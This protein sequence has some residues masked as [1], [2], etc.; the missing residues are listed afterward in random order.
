MKKI[1]FTLLLFIFVLKVMGQQC[2]PINYTGPKPALA[3]NYLVNK[4]N[5]RFANANIASRSADI[6]EAWL[7]YAVNLEALI[8]NG[9]PYIAPLF[10]DSSVYFNYGPTSY[11][12]AFSYSIGQ[13]FNA[14]SVFFTSTALG[15]YGI[16][17]IDLT[18]SEAYTLDSIAP[19]IAYYRLNR[20]TSIVD[21]LVINLYQG[22]SQSTIFPQ[23]YFTGN[24]ASG[25]IDSYYGTDTVFFPAIFYNYKTYGVLDSNT[26]GSNKINITPTTIK[27]LLH[28]KDTAYLAHE[29]AVPGGLNVAVGNLVGCTV[30]YKPQ[31]GTWA[32]GDTLSH[33]FNYAEYQ[34]L[35]EN[36]TDSV[37]LYT[38]INRV[39]DNNISYI[40]PQE[41]QY[42]QSIGG[43]DSSYIPTIAF[44]PGFQLQDNYI[45]YHIS[46]QITGVKDLTS[47]VS[48]QSIYPNPS[49][50]Q[51]MLN[52]TLKTGASV[53]INVYDITGKLIRS[54]NEGNL[55][56][57]QNQQVINTSDLTDGIYLVSIV[58]NGNNSVS[59]LVVAR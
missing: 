18:S 28:Q 51:A 55:A 32:P 25:T 35:D 19:A 46:Y 20:D 39:P 23:Y 9:Q 52:Y 48:N 1:T 26:I 34:A 29:I 40:A 16:D 33:G 11:G 2:N 13:T 14:Y 44:Y 37:P 7:S 43:W 12:K 3:N 38:V 57:G 50:D 31:S 24:F 8:G 56:A 36:N 59:K 41:V 58:A 22:T 42:N 10:T 53:I 30:A 5:N 45:Y 6:G 47:P 49:A 54:K 4:T 27:I 15:G 21:T 17:T